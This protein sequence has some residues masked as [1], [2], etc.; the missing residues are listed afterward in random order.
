MNVEPR[1]VGPW[2]LVS[3]LV[4]GE[5]ASLLEAAAPIRELPT[6]CKPWTVEGV[7]AHLTQ[8]FRRFGEMLAQGRAGD[9]APPFAPHEISQVNLKA[10][11]EFEGDA[12]VALRRNAESFLAAV[13]DPDEPMPHQMGVIPAGLQV[14]FAL[15][16]VVLH[17]DDV[18]DARG[19]RYRPGEEVVDAMVHLWEGVLELTEIEIEEAWARILE[20]SGRASSHHDDRDRL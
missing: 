12:F 13:T 15:S 3:D 6:R 17:R 11:E 7:T 4:R 1:F 18:E 20:A 2:P 5:V 16:E 9:F 14:R 19:A 8:T 10:V